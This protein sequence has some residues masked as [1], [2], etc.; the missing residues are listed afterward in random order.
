L[1]RRLTDRFRVIVL[2]PHASGAKSR[3]NLDGVE[4]VRYRYAPAAL[5]TLINDGGIIGNLTRSPWKL[6]LVPLLLVAQILT[7]WRLMRRQRVDVIHAHGLIPQGVIAAV[8]QRLPGTH[9]PFL[10]TS[11]GADL[12][13]FKG[14]L[15]TRLKAWVARRAQAATV[16]SEAMRK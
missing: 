3:D 5:E 1:A 8:L 4:V 15:V 13:A 11:H 10:V 12:F 6:L 9:P 16:V 7:A 2:A 14:K